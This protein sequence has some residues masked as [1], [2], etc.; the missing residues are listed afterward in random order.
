M[1]ESNRLASKGRKW[2]DPVGWLGDAPRRC[3]Y[4]SPHPTPRHRGRASKFLTDDYR[5]PDP[6]LGCSHNSLSYSPESIIPPTRTARARPGALSDSHR[7]HSEF[8][9]PGQ[10]E[11]GPVP[12]SL[13]H[14]GAL[15]KPY[16]CRALRNRAACP[17]HRG[18][19][20]YPLEADPP[21]YAQKT[22]LQIFHFVRF[23]RIL[24]GV[25]MEET[26]EFPRRS[27]RC[28]ST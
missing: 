20:M 1:V 7:I 15:S 11:C 14:R 19:G 5:S 8:I 3:P 10:D 12:M 13:S 6:I 2:A 17:P 27:E 16:G 4:H 21:K 24:V 18:R 25:G 28:L 9:A 22:L 23:F 26:D